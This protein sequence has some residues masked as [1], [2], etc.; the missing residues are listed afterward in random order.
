MKKITMT[1][2]FFALLGVL[3]IVPATAKTE[4]QLGNFASIVA[5]QICVNLGSKYSYGEG[6]CRFYL[7]YRLDNMYT[8]A[9]AA[10]SC[11]RDYCES[12]QTTP[13]YT[14][15]RQACANMQTMD[16]TQ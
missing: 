9:Q 16:A 13:P 8:K 14:E 6:A 11:V 7:H 3:F 12:S 1:I 2:I 15:C 5:N 10:N 4:I